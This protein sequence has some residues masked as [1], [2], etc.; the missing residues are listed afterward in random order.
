MAYNDYD[1]F[2]SGDK[3]ANYKVDIVLRTLYILTEAVFVGMFCSMMAGVNKQL[4]L[5]FKEIGIKDYP[6]RI[7]SGLLAVIFISGACVIIE[8]I[9]YELV[10]DFPDILDSILLT[11]Y[12]E[13]L[14]LTMLVQTLG[15][16]YLLDFSEA[17]TSE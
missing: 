14:I 16:L 13:S 4:S 10:D 17:N 5:F 1:W 12:G 11:A 3:E 6:Y 9:V 15:F 7:L 8:C 2:G